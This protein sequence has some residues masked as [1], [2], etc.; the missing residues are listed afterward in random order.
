MNQHGMEKKWVPH[1][2]SALDNFKVGK[3]CLLTAVGSSGGRMV[4]AAIMVKVIV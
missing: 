3:N 4:K 2:G 1:L